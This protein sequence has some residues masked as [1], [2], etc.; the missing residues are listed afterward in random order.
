MPERRSGATA[1]SRHLRTAGTRVK[2][3][4]S[5]RNQGCWRCKKDGI[6]LSLRTLRGRP[7]LD[8]NDIEQ[9]RGDACVAEFSTDLFA[10]AT[11]S[12]NECQG[13]EDEHCDL[14]LSHKPPGS[15]IAL[16]TLSTRKSGVGRFA[17]RF[18]F[19]ALNE[20]GLCGPQQMEVGP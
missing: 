16:Q 2:H 20:A 12:G 4:P 1:A 17:V 15:I 14:E 13:C 5:T 18:T 8:T 19:C 9:E 10:K 3:V 7:Q 6:A 11:G